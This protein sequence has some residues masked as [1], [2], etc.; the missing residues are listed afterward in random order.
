MPLSKITF[1]KDHGDYKAGTTYDLESGY[2]TRLVISGVA[3][4]GTPEPPT[5][6]PAEPVEAGSIDA[7]PEIKTAVSRP[8]TPRK[9]RK[10]K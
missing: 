8:R 1:V 10:Y 2:A 7:E 4:L 6:E 9:K 5:T 3:V